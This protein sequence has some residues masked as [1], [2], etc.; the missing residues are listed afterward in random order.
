ML[1]CVVKPDANQNA[2][3]DI[4]STDGM[5]LS[6]A[7]SEL[8]Q[9]R[10]ENDLPAQHCEQIIDAMK[11]K[12]FSRWAQLVM[13]ESNQLHACCLDTSPPIFYMNSS[14]KNIV[15]LVRDLNRESLAET[16]QFIASYSIDAGFHVFVFCL[17]KDRQFV[18]ERIL[19]EESI[20][21][22]TIIEAKINEH[23]TQHCNINS[24]NFNFN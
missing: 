8:L 3:K 14:S 9:M 10:I 5:R 21:L 11:R 2:F 18:K 12:D 23:G 16:G 6:L 17:N 19:K 20:R 1:I 4:P 7:T 24:Q 22:E 13:Q 15:N